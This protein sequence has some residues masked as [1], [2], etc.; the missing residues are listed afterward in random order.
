MGR[1]VAGS[2]IALI[3]L[4]GCSSARPQTTTNSEVAKSV[5]VTAA[6]PLVAVLPHHDLVR[7]QRQE[8][9]TTL[10]K[11]SQPE[12]IIVVSPNHFSAGQASIQ[13]TDRIWEIDGGT[14]MI[15]PNHAVV[16][17]L[18]S[19]GV[20]SMDD[21]SFNSEHGIKNILS[22][23]HA[24]FPASNLVSIILKDTTSP[25]Q[26]NQLTQALIT[27]CSNCGLIA[28]V[29]MSHYNPAAVADVHDIKTLR[30]LQTLDTADIWK[31]EVDSPPSL[32]LLLYWAQQQ[33]VEQFVVA[34]HTNSGTLLGDA[35]AE[36]TTHI[37]GYY[38]AGAPV[39]VEDQL[40]FT[41]AGDMMYGREIGYQFQENN[42]QE[43]FRN[44]GN[45]LFW[46][47]D[48]SW[49]NLEGPVSDQTVIQN[50]QPD[51]LIFLFSKETVQALR[52]LKLTSVGL[53]NNHTANQ[54]LKGFSTTQTMVESVG[55]DWVGDP[56]GINESSIDRYM[57]GDLVLSVIA[58]NQF[59]GDLSGLTDLISTED[60][61]GHF[62]LVLPH[63]G[64]EYAT[65]HTTT[66]ERLATE[67]IEAGADLIIG[68]HP[69]VV[70]DA[71]VINEK[72][73]LYSL[74]N[75]I[76]DQT[77]STETQEGLVVTGVLSSESV[78]I[79][80]VP[81]VSNRLQPQLLSGAAK[82][83]MFDHVCANISNYCQAGVITIPR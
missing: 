63:W 59:D 31:V 47:T 5:V 69:H 7:T 57:Q 20:A 14:A 83:R 25:D 4:G 16:D 73:V 22:D 61:A 40:T 53:A 30:A 44:L 41:F 19:A 18:V 67:W 27:A 56:Y 65:Q 38:T 13:T 42:Y 66:Q 62:V 17:A 28:S 68:M 9:L 80:L 1:L 71:Q 54:G 6:V 26:L 49:A 76:F 51:D 75:F 82:Q 15:E 24:A 10:A 36:T 60:S 3:I 35:D 79:T 70:E 74:G 58:V 2:I 81:I 52:Y 45:R 32:A 21:S 55:V 48:V 34:D 46:G 12:T 37:L 77:F 39:T 33:Q 72:L 43:L 64:T 50:R 11:R 8:M 23:L 29:D 78:Q